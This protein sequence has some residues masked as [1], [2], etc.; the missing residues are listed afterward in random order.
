MPETT[1]TIPAIH[2]E[3]CV[4][5]IREA[6]ATLPGTDVTAADPATKQV[7]VRFDASVTNLEQIREALDQIGFSPADEAER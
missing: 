6:L 2:C 3:H 7:R 5:S 1:L 4:Q